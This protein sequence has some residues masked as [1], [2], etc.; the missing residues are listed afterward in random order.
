MKSAISKPKE[1]KGNKH[2]R[3]EGF[4]MAVIPFIG[5]LAFTGFPMVLS[6]FISF[7]DLHSY[8]LS[9]MTFVGLD[10]YKNMFTMPLFQTAL[11]NT[12]Y[13]CLSVPINLVSQLFLANLLTKP[14]NP[15][16][17]KAAR[18]ILYIPTVIG[19]VAI[20]LIWNWILEANYGVINTILMAIGMEKV[21]FTTTREW[22]MP[23]VLLIKWWS[24]GLNIL[25]FQAALSNVNASLK[26]AARIDGALDRQVFFRVTLPQ[27]APILIYTCTMNIIEAFGEISTMQIISGNGLGPSNSAVTLSYMMYRMAY[28]NIFTE[29]F[30]MASA[31]G[32]VIGIITI[33]F[34]RASTWASKKWLSAD[35]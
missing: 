29:G 27:I 34:V 7:H 8:D 11:V 6:L 24:V 4:C 33:I 22:F 17:A 23:S 19:G 31:L 2:E 3:I 13:F 14:L 15:H 20:S 26:E 18:L 1:F 21:G 9:Q 12:L 5:F 16:F 10:N 35:D 25:V 32:W 30:G 28:V